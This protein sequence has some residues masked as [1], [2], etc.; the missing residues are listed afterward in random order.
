MKRFK[1]TLVIRT[2]T[3]L[4]ILGVIGLCQAVQIHTHTLPHILPP[5]IRTHSHTHTHSHAHVTPTHTHTHTHTLPHAL[6]HSHTHTHTHTHTQ[7][8]LAQ[9][10]EKSKQTLLERN[11]QHLSPYSQ[12]IVVD[13][14]YY[15]ALLVSASHDIWNQG[16]NRRE[17]ILHWNRRS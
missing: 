5:P 10:H 11:S 3:S 4:Q 9:C 8:N 7:S 6:T 2:K 14:H 1:R 12:S 17:K 13:D 15:I 16:N